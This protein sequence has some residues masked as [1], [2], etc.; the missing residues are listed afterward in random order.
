MAIAISST[1]PLLIGLVCGIACALMAVF[2]ATDP[3]PAIGR[4][5]ISDNEVVTASERLQWV[6]QTVAELAS[7][8][9][10]K[11]LLPTKFANAGI[12]YKPL[13]HCV[14]ISRAMCARLSDAD[15]RLILAHE[16]GHAT[17][18]YSTWGAF[19]ESSRITEEI[20]ADE[21]ALHLTGS[22]KDDWLRA[23]SAALHAEGHS[24]CPH[25]IAAH[26]SA[27]TIDGSAMLV[28]KSC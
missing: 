5:I 16:I 14:N 8:A 19:R 24:G 11:P 17:R 28:S 21:I 20:R 27:L 10:I 23:M 9:Q 22:N 15:L 1:L 12:Y 4:V 26:L 18:R 13:W 7:R 25:E 2:H 3:D 6:N